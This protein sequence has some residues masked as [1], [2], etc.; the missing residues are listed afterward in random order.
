[1]FVVFETDRIVVHAGCLLVFVQSLR[2]LFISSQFYHCWR[3]AKSPSRSQRAL[4]R[5]LHP[6]FGDSRQAVLT[7]TVTSMDYVCWH[8]DCA[9]LYDLPAALLCVELVPTVQEVHKDIL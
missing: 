7:L 9:A 5:R 1:M 2:R 6:A 3:T 8:I 4:C